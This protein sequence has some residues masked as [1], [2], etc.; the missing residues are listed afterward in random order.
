MSQSIELNER[1]SSNEVTEG[2][3]LARQGHFKDALQVFEQ[4]LGFTQDPTA[5]SYYALSLSV[6]ERDHEQGI[7]LCLMA[8][9][10]DSYNPDIYLNTAKVLFIQNR[11]FQAVKAIRKGLLLDSK[12]KS[13]LK[14]H[15]KIGIRKRPVLSFLS[16]RSII[17][18][19]LGK[20]NVF[21]V[22]SSIFT[23]R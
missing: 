8:L 5:M 16:R 23:V 4:N 1:F 2:V 6:V 22:S 20:L 11:K 12:H 21:R 15:Q 17:N 19:L 14:F 3:I 9:R 10:R 7:N 18:I 13:L